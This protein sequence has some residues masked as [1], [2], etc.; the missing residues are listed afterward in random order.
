MKTVVS[1]G[2]TLWD[3]LPSGPALGGAPCNLALRVKEVGGRALLVTRLGRDALGDQAAERLS[4]RGLDLRLVQRDDGRPTGTVPVTVDAKGVPDFTIVPDVAYDYIEPSE[5]ALAAAATADAVAF[6]TLAQRSAVSR[7][8]LERL[9]SRANRAL[10]FLDLNLRRGC[11]TPETVEA[12]LRRADVVKLNEDE[13]RTLA[14][15]FGLP[16]G[17]GRAL[18]GAVQ[19]R[20]RLDGVVVTLGNRGAVGVKGS[21]WAYAPARETAI[22]DTCGSG[23]AFSAAF[24]HAW[25]EGRPLSEALQRG[26]ALGAL[27]AGQPGGAG[28][29][30][31]RW[32]DRLN[33]MMPDVRWDEQVAFWM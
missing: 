22:V 19:G 23:D 1:F 29:L 24:L 9:L 6:G 32:R 8:A 5:E 13:A 18:L 4:A 30:P 10:K 2:E 26:N 14:E 28:P 16:A 25:L 17:P 31:E 12:S 20:W 15:R 21:E 11:W 7:A 3:L 33:L 27:V